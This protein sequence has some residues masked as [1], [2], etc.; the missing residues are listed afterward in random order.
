L[1]GAILSLATLV[2]LRLQSIPPQYLPIE[3]NN[4]SQFKAQRHT[5]MHGPRQEVIGPVFL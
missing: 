1:T 4:T 2:P 5:T 3:T